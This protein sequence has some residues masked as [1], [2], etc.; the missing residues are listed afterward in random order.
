MN[1]MLTNIL[2]NVEYSEWADNAI[3][4][5]LKCI[6]SSTNLH[7]IETCQKM[8]N[9]FVVV[10]IVNSDINDKTMVNIITLLNNYLNEK[11]LRLI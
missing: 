6:D 3:D 8:I 7:H 5:I 10:S 11:K 1:S 9:Q 4:K 2:F